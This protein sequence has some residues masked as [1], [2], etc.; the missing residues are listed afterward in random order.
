LQRFRVAEAAARD[1]DREDDRLAL[2]R[3][4]LLA[5]DLGRQAGPFCAKR[6]ALLADGER[7]GRVDRVLVEDAE[8][9]EAA[10]HLS[11]GVEGKAGSALARQGADDVERE[12]TTHLA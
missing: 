2:G 12:T 3:L 10:S 9:G 11:A 5:L 8:R 7:Y 4:G 6:R 1:V